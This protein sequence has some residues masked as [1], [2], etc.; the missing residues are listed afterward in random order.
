MAWLFFPFS[1]PQSQAP[2]KSEDIKFHK[3]IHLSD[4]LTGA[5]GATSIFTVPPGLVFVIQSIEM[6]MNVT[7]VTAAPQPAHVEVRNQAGTFL[8]YLLT[9]MASGKGLNWYD[10]NPVKVQRHNNIVAGPHA[11]NDRWTYTV[12]PNRIAFVEALTTR[13]TRVT[14]AAPSSDAHCTI[15]T[16]IAVCFDSIIYTNIVGDTDK[17]VVGQN[18]ILLAGET[19]IGR[20]RDNST[21]GTINYVSDM[22][23]SQ[24][25]MHQMENEVIEFPDGVIVPSG[26][27]VYVNRPVVANDLYYSVSGWLGVPKTPMVDW[28]NT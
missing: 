19:I 7:G 12:P 24:F 8:D 28:F 13:V 16:D 14:V 10:R 15:V 21:G 27:Q 11:A 20:T 25:E 22:I 1:F 9:I 18:M 4:H 2:P 17:T 26:H 3:Q 6:S 23:A 5:G